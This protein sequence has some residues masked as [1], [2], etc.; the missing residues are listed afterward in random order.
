MESVR[1]QRPVHFLRD[2]VASLK[3]SN[4]TINTNHADSAQQQCKPNST[5]K[6]YSSCPPETRINSGKQTIVIVGDSIIKQLDEKE[7]YQTEKKNVTVR[8][9]TV[10]RATTDDIKEYCKPNTKRRPDIC[11]VHK[12]TNDLNKVSITENIFKVKEIIE[13]S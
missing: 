11:I 6:S 9:P 8:C 2:Q 10:F 1:L 7:S 12:G 4:P 5:N 3:P 13:K